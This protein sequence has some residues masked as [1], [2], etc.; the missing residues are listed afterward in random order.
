MA[1]RWVPP[2][3]PSSAAC[4]CSWDGPPTSARICPL[5]MRPFPRAG[6][7]AH[8]RGWRPRSYP[9]GSKDATR[10]N[11]GDLGLGE[12][13]P[14]GTFESGRRRAGMHPTTRSAM[15]ARLCRQSG[16]GLRVRPEFFPAER[17]PGA[18]RPSLMAWCGRQLLPARSWSRSA[19]RSS[20]TMRRADFETQM[21][22]VREQR[23]D[24]QAAETAFADRA[25]SPRRGSMASPLRGRA[26]L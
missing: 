6:V 1:A 4:R 19:A 15:S 14:V 9:Q 26:G 25:R 7:A 13:M 17:P 22:F 10:A 2:R 16:V 12:R 3:S 21:R 18:Q 23:Y 8:H 11:T 20:A 24:T 5:A